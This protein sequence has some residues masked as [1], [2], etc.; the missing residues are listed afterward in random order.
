MANE[1]PS[2]HRVDAADRLYFVNDAWLVFARENA[3]TDLAPE[4]VL[5]RPLWDFIAGNDAA[6]VFR[7]LLGEVR[8]L[9]R[10]VRLPFRCDA[11]AV[12][13]DMELEIVPLPV[14]AVEFR[15]HLELQTVRAPV[16][17]LD[18]SVARAR[19]H[20]PICSWC[21][22]V[23]VSAG[24]WKGT[25]AAV[26]ALGLFSSASMPRL[27]H[28]ICPA[29]TVAIRARSGADGPNSKGVR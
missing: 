14:G 27:M 29:C 9:Q 1:E 7:V 10:V 5:G 28:T 11:P 13:R 20:V 19:W 24:A 4:S 8:T 17:L 26:E 23:E 2:I 18:A 25:E 22:G 16:P 21:K 12:R 6:H 3:A 15:S